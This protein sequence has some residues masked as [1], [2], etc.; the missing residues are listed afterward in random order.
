M[1]S[2]LGKAER[3][4]V[5]V[6]G[7]SIGG[8]VAIHL[9]ATNPDRIRFV[10]VENTFLSIPRLIPAVMPALR[11]FA[12]LCHQVWDNS[13]TVQRVGQRIL[14]L[15]GAKDELVPPRHMREL[16]TLAKR[17][18]DRTFI[19]FDKGTH[20]DTCIQP[21]YF[22]AIEQFLLRAAAPPPRVKIEEVTDE[23]EL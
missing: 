7:Q 10:L 18:Y 2:R 19:V 17:S 15:S 14:F 3:E 13:A 21:G 8:A 5:A 12:R 22:E 16:Q 11:P 1:W 23:D 6:Y 20:N 4:R 9:A